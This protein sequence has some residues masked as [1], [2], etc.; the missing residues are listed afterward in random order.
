[1]TLESAPGQGTDITLSFPA[2]QPTHHAEPGEERVVPAP[3]EVLNVLSGYTVLLVDDEPLVLKAGVRML[4]TLGA[5][6]IS[7]DSGVEAA[8]LVEKH[9]TNI[10]LVVLDLIM[11]G[12]DGIGTMRKIHSIQP[13]M[14]V[15]LV[16]GYAKD[17]LKPEHMISD[18]DFVRF[19][20]KPYRA[21]QISR[22]AESLLSA[23][24]TRR[25]SQSSS[26]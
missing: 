15:V 25:D 5:D 3:A 14:P 2:R 8:G 6:V 20:A 18:G 17:I 26:A 11:P 10:S 1:I 24:E 16:S 9:G 4:K 7:A 21:E 19:L 12:L 22:V 13:G 23:S